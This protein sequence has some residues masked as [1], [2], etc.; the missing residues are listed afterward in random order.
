MET[1]SK[2]AL[3]K[4]QLYIADTTRHIWTQTSKLSLSLEKIK[5]YMTGSGGK[6]FSNGKKYYGL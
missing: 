5:T 1:L 3:R 4:I 6:L 2:K